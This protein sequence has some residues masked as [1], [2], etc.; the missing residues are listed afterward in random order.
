MQDIISVGKEQQAVQ[1]SDKNSSLSQSINESLSSANISYSIKFKNISRMIISLK[2]LCPPLKA[3][4][5]IMFRKKSN[6][7]DTAEFIS[8]FFKKILKPIKKRRKESAAKMKKSKSLKLLNLE[9]KSSKLTQRNKKKTLQ[10]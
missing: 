4:R 8:T 7:A 10:K 6:K 9:K 3:K 2:E 1:V 5:V